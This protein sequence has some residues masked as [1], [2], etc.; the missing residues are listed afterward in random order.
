MEPLKIDHCV[1]NGRNNRNN[2]AILIL[3]YVYK[4]KGD[5]KKVF[6]LFNRLYQLTYNEDS[7]EISVL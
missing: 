4:D 3:L 6:E 2:I 7:D 5:Y 1:L